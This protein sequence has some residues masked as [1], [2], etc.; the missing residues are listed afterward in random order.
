ME[1]V[2][3]DRT[4]IWER[5]EAFF[6]AR[7]EIVFEWNDPLSSAR[8]WLVI[9]S[10][11]GGAAGGGTR[12]RVGL[13]RDEVTFLAKAMELKFALSGPPIGGA[14]SGIAFDAS[15][16]AKPEILRRWFTA[17]RGELRSRYGT[18][19]DLN[20][21][22][23]EDVI[24]L[25]TEVDVEHPQMGVLRGHFGLQGATLTERCQLMRQGLDTLVPA[26]YG[27]AGKDARVFALVTGYSVA[28]SALRLLERQGRDPRG[29]RVLLQGFGA[30]GG[31]AALYMARA[32]LDVVGICD[33]R[34]ALLA[35]EGLGADAVEKLL[36]S[37]RGNTLPETL[38][39]EFGANERREEFWEVPA[40]LFVAAAASGTLDGT[41]LDQLE[42]AGVE[43]IVSGA[44]HPFAAEQ[45]G[46]THIERAADERFAIVA[47]VIASC[48]TARAFACA[49][50]SDRAL[51]PE[52]VFR[53]IR[54]TVGEAVDESVRRA[55]STERGLLAGALDLALDRAARAPA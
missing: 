45:P 52:T 24:P 37:R 5:V 39:E 1:A 12:M 26:P 7:P 36:L 29:V 16:A 19:G 40:D 53:A 34:D 42:A 21:S 25:C 48:G 23:S 22:E 50:A 55:G 44:N 30:V 31:A 6:R 49:A 11:K 43:T 17:I 33:A 38:N 27:L 13:N 15:D 8:G 54:H 3:T 20:V 35:P 28:Q 10:L 18:A 4:A 14:K 51:E 41:R 2:A 9:N 32:G 46:D 47:D